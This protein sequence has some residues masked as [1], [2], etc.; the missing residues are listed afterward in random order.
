MNRSPTLHMQL[1]HGHDMTNRLS[2][3][4]SPYLLQH[5]NNPVDWFAWGKEAFEEAKSRD[6]PILLSIGYS[7]C[8]WCHVME[9]ESFENES[10]A[11]LMNQNFVSVKVD[12][13]ERPDIDSIYMSAVQSMTGQGGWPL[14]VF[15]TGD[16]LPFFGGTYYPP[17]ARGG[18][19]GFPQ[20]LSSIS[21]AYKDRRSEIEESG[22]YLRDHIKQSAQSPHTDDNMEPVLLDRAYQQLSTQHDWESGGFGNSIKFPQTMALE[23]LLRYHQKHPTS[24]AL[25]MVELSLQKMAS[26]GMYD[27][28]GGGFHRYSTDKNWIVPHFEKM[29]YD[30]ALLSRLYIHAYLITG[31]KLYIDVAEDIFRYIDNEMTDKLGLFYSAEDADSDGKEGTYYIW[32]YEELQQ[33]LDEQEFKQLQSAFTLSPKGNFEGKNIL[34]YTLSGT[35]LGFLDSDDLNLQA[36]RAKLTKQRAVRNK[37]FRDEKNLLSWNALMSLSFIDGYFIT[38][39]EKW[40]NKAILNAN[41]L[42]S[43]VDNDSGVFHSYKAGKVGSYGYLEDYAALL[44]LMLSLHEAT[45]D[46]DWLTRAEFFGES[47]IQLFWDS[48]ESRLYDTPQDGETLIIRPGESYDNATP[49]GSSMA[50]EGLYKLS[51][52]T[53]NEQYRNIVI[54]LLAST[55]SIASEHP[56][57]FGNW[58]CVLDSFLY[59]TLEIAIVAEDHENAIKMRDCLFESYVP[60]HIFCGNA[61]F[62]RSEKFRNKWDSYPL[63]T[64]REPES[65]KA[66]AFLCENYACELPVSSP[67]EFL[68]LIRQKI[69]P[70]QK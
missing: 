44:L 54:S 5:K 13:E 61:S 70:A 16:G 12:R 51:I 36:I 49:S 46:L 60:N 30:N 24:Q 7:S 43:I 69:N 26:G 57:S 3:E 64:E 1:V 29:L 41:S 15:L 19:P 66:T 9:Y 48:H 25:E 47:L 35:H 39:D 59:P 31:R 10:I 34:H 67:K 33:I 63:L 53:N 56:I 22:S 11:K 8:H 38:K 40:L 18:M 58:L 2:K 28:L 65:N 27:Q 68:D 45:L 20:L 37:P 21:D 42:L 23:F 6:V 62:S 55:S 32:D 14:T 4:S 50:V 17:E 52:I